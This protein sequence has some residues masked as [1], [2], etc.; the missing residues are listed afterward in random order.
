M[1]PKTD[2]NQ[3]FALVVV[4]MVLLLVTALAAE[5]IFTVR[6]GIQEGRQTK[7]NTINRG[8]AKAGINLALFYLADQPLEF[9][10]DGPYIPGAITSVYLDTGKVNF[11]TISESGKINLNT[12]NRPL[13][14]QFLE[15]QGYEPDEQEILIDSME[16]WIDNDDLHRLNGAENDHYEALPVPY[17]AKNGPFTDPSEILLVRGAE[18]L[19]GKINPTDFFTIYNPSGQINFNMLSPSMLHTITS[20]NEERIQQYHELKNESISLGADHAQLILDENYAIWQPYLV[21]SKGNNQYYTA[22]ATGLA[23]VIN[24]DEHSDSVINNKKHSGWRIQLLLSQTKN[25]FHYIRWSEGSI[26]E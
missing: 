22:T 11:Q 15:Q 23:G 20:G 9:A 6:T 4:I 14:S 25:T 16:D 5:M 18:K 17:Q 26:V 1:T 3:G 21:Y 7:L 19:I 10:E 24:I 8:L 12:I 2:Q 13:L